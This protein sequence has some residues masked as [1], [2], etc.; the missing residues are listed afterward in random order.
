MSILFVGTICLLQL[1]AA[2]VYAWSG[3]WK[4]AGFWFFV[5]LANAAITPWRAS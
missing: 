1:G 5:M 3:Q 2:I 4:L